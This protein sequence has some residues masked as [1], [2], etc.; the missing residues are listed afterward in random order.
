MPSLFVSDTGKSVYLE[1]EAIRFYSNKPP[2][3]T[4]AFFR[5]LLCCFAPPVNQDLIVKIE[6]KLEVVFPDLCYCGFAKSGIRMWED[7]L[8]ISK[9]R[10]GYIDNNIGSSLLNNMKIPCAEALDIYRLLSLLSDDELAIA[11]PWA[12]KGMIREEISHVLLDTATSESSNAFFAHKAVSLICDS[13]GI[14]D[15]MVLIANKDLFERP[16]FLC[17]IVAFQYL[18]K[19]AQKENNQNVVDF[20]QVIQNP[21][22]N[23]IDKEDRKKIFLSINTCDSLSN[24]IHR[25]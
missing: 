13:I 25:F 10:F 24:L 17:A 11:Q 12:T 1:D 19:R 3:L 15:A 14:E 7:S 8:P 6:S 5:S 22:T 2:S 4:R 9:L 20:I 18:L 16:N 21:E 23:I